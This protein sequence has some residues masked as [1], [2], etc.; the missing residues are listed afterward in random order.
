MLRLTSWIACLAGFPCAIAAKA[1]GRRGR[2]VSQIATAIF[3]PRPDVKAL[4]ESL[5]LG[6]FG[7]SG[8]RR[9][10]LSGLNLIKFL[11]HSEVNRGALLSLLTQY[12]DFM[13]ITSFLFLS[14]SFFCS[15]GDQS[16]NTADGDSL[17][18]FTVGNE[19]SDSLRQYG[20]DLDLVRVNET[21]HLKLGD[22]EVPVQIEDR[23]D[24]GIPDRIYA[25]VDLPP[26]TEGKIVAYAG[27]GTEIPEGIMVHAHL[28]NGKAISSPHLINFDEEW[29]ANGIII[30]NEWLGYRAL[31]SPPYAIDIIGKKVPAML[32]SPVLQDLSKINNWGG[33]ALDEGLSLGIGSP[34]LFDQ[35][36]IIS[37]TKFDSREV[38]ILETGPLRA[39][40][41]TKILGVPIR[42]EKVDL[43]IKWQ[44][45]G[46]K[47]WA[48]LDVSIISKTDLNLQ[49]AFGLPKH[50][51]ATDFT[52]ALVSNVHCAYTFG[53]QS[54][55]KE[56]LGM[57][58]MV[59]ARF[60]TDTYRD[61]PHNY[62]YLA[63]PINQSV[64]YRIIS[65]WGKGRI[66]VYDEVEFFN[67][68]RRYATEYGATVKVQPDF[69]L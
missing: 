10:A 28:D 67:L 36:S 38:S 3:L 26:R 32:D 33:D 24:N 49:F 39:E 55:E 17:F 2:R 51:E 57:A 19:S 29:A 9:P 65:F 25:I 61:D 15:C 31:M 5:R 18:D 69:R 66:P 42:G 58:I 40:V 11:L 56:H 6:G 37:L 22:Q 41:Q 7:A 62:F 46:G 64:Q 30:E 52:Q 14:I 53:L 23:N 54:S 45:Q 44:M 13:R 48:Q 60:E 21:F 47:P 4:G 63:T 1:T 68:I 27:P 35:A 43:L 16:Q 12:S 59:P 8:G 50:E 20:V 34:A